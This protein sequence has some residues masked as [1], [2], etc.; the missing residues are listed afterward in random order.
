M[1]KVNADVLSVGERVKLV[2]E[3]GQEH[4]LLD[5]TEIYSC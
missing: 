5:L 3:S 1:N 2:R 4:A